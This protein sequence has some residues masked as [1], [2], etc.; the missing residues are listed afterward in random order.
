MIDELLS[1][2]VKV[3][4]LFTDDGQ[5]P[6]ETPDRRALV[7]L[8]AYGAAAGAGYFLHEYGPE[9]GTLGDATTWAALPLL[10]CFFL[11]WAWAIVCWN[12]LAL[13]W[14]TRGYRGS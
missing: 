4:A 3:P 13:W 5:E 2:V 8:L 11:A 10:L 9:S 14:S 6:G 7:Y 1:R 12:R